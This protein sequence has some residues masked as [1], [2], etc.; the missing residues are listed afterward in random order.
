MIVS[1]KKSEFQ[2]YGEGGCET[3]ARMKAKTYSDEEK[4]KYAVRTAEDAEHQ[5]R[6]PTDVVHGRWCDK[7]DD[8]V[9]QPL[10]GGGHRDTVPSK[11]RGEDFRDEDPWRR[12]PRH[13]V[14]DDVQVNHDD[15][16]NGGGRDDVDVCRWMRREHGADDEHH[17]CHPRCARE[18]S[19]AA[20][21]TVDTEDEE[22]CGCAD[23]YGSIHACVKTQLSF[24]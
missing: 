10:R 18:E 3:R 13:G 6:P 4:D 5:E 16:G 9:E 21:E 23:F 14:S 8:E 20:A 2:R 7:G 12:T 24:F 1:V 19:F 11:S 17:N 22:E 15:H